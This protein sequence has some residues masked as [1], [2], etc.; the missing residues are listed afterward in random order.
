M[1][2]RYIGHSGFLMEW[3]ACYWLFDYYT[4]DIPQMDAEKKVFVFVSHKHRD[5]WNPRVL[6]LRNEYPDIQYVLSSDIELP[7][8]D[9]VSKMVTRV[10]PERQY[11]LFDGNGQAIRLTTLRSTDAGIAFLLGYLGKCVYH[12]GDL[13]LWMWK[14]EPEEYNKEMAAAFDEQMNRL[15]DV[16]IDVAFVP[17]DPRQEEYHYLG[18]EALLQKAKVK[19]VFPMH[20]GSEFAVIE[21]YKKERAA[22]LSG[23]ILADIRRAGEEWEIDL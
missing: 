5:H 23:T 19:R 21:R 14:E 20:F 7:E 17:L 22:N 4:G 11:D 9:W 3:K 6:D 15:K 2:I 16:A 13:N 8:Q 1:K 12:A 18:L 10:E